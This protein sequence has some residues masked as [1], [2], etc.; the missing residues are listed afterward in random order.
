MKDLRFATIVEHFI[1][2]ILKE[3]TDV[4]LLPKLH[5]MFA[6]FFFI[7]NSFSVQFLK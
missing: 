5:Q 1:Y 4:E 6:F 7:L 2:G 3:N